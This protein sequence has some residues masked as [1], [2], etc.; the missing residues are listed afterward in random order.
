MPA[1]N[2][3]LAANCP[4]AFALRNFDRN[5]EITESFDDMVVATVRATKLY[6]RDGQVREA[7]GI[8]ADGSAW[9][10][11]PQTGGRT[12]AN[13]TGWRLV[14]R[15]STRRAHLTLVK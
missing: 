13:S 12:R 11:E 5:D 8:A 6:K 2:T 14:R 15:L 4:V 1:T 3:A 9:T 10:I 7:V